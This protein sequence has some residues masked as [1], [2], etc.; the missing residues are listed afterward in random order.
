MNLIRNKFGSGIVVN[1]A[2]LN[3]KTYITTAACMSVF[4]ESL[5]WANANKCNVVHAPIDADNI[6]VLSCQ[7]TD[8]AILNDFDTIE[9]LRKQYPGKRFFIGGCLAQRFDVSMPLGVER[10]DHLRSD[11]QE[12]KHLNLINYEKPFWVKNFRDDDSEFAEGHLFRK[13]YPLRVGAGCHGKCKYCTIKVTRGKAYNL[14]HDKLAAEFARH[15]DILIVADSIC[16]EQIST[17]SNMAT[18]YNKKI[19]F[20][21][22]EPQNVV[23]A[24]KEL[25]SLADKKLLRIL[26]TPVQAFNREVLKLM[27]RDV[28]QTHEAL[29]VVRK[30][31]GKGVFTATNIIIDYCGYENEFTKVYE[32]F[33]YVTLNPYWDGVWNLA[34]ARDRW[35]H[36]FNKFGT[37][38]TN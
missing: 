22:V 1:Q 34:K 13:M 30:L 8:L 5:G 37:S 15:D 29:E 35:D 28:E 2:E 18:T 20:R 19:S 24:K 14:D 11:Y 7:V 38:T 9:N 17:Y 6:V 26:H 25:F 21:N 32:L 4:S 3:G 10:L 12:L 31:R 36:Y 33:D 23:K 16:A 27:N